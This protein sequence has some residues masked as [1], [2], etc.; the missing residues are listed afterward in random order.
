L[1]ILERFIGKFEFNPV[2]KPIWVW[3]RLYLTTKSYHLKQKRLDYR[4]LFR[5]PPN[6]TPETRGNGA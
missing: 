4:K 3:L 6:Q 1:K 2:R 5:S